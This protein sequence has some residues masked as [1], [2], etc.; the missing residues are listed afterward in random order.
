MI[1]KQLLQQF[2]GCSRVAPFLNDEIENLAFIINSAPQ[3]HALAANLADH[4]VEVPTWRWRKL[5]TAKVG[6]D[7]RTELH[8]PGADRLVTHIDAP[9]REHLFDIAQAEREAEVQPH[10]MLNDGCRETVPFEGNSRHWVLPEANE[11]GLPETR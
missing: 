7:L 11:Q 8:R 3:E 1:P 5:A 4:F 10:R 9:L 6:G 2:Q